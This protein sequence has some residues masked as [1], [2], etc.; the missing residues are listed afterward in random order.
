MSRTLPKEKILATLRRIDPYVFEKFIGEVWEGQ[1]YNTT[2]RRGSDDRG[3]DVV[4][5]KRT[6]K[7]LLQVKRYS[8]E[9]KV[10][11]QKVRKY[12]TLYQQVGDADQVIIITSGFFTDEAKT[13]G[14][15]LDVELIDA[16]QLF[17]LVQK[18]TPDLATDYLE[19][20]YPTRCSDSTGRNPFNH[21]WK[22]SRISENQGI[23]DNCPECIRGHIW[24]GQLKNNNRIRLKCERCDSMWKEDIEQD[25]W[26]IFAREKNVGWIRM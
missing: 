15:N 17:D 3:I 24:L 1:G 23:F 25:G 13:L 18:Y 11:S 10:G 16:D 9:N 4:A 19:G 21:P 14:R 7:E 6:K 22:F 26:W 2:V 5:T 8:S 20:D 12:A